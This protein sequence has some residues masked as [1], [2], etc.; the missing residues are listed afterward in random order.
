MDFSW[1]EEQNLWRKTVREFANKNIKPIVRDIDSNKKR[2]CVQ[3][4][5]KSFFKN[6]EIQSG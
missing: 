4:V 5:C 2:I 6:S 3:I 1:T